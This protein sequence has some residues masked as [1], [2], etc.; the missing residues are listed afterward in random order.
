[1]SKIAVGANGES[2]VHVALRVCFV[3][4]VV[5]IEYLLL[6][7]TSGWHLEICLRKSP[8]LCI[9]LPT[10]HSSDW[11]YAKCAYFHCVE[12][13]SHLFRVAT[14]RV[15]LGFCFI[16]NRRGETPLDD[17]LILHLCRF[18]VLLSDTVLLHP[19]SPKGSLRSCCRYSPILSK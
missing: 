1:M 7:T 16:K 2:G 6:S 19:S 4:L 13:D 5:T 8:P 17:F 10:A 14:A 9:W 3:Y 11:L 15:C 12:D 18:N